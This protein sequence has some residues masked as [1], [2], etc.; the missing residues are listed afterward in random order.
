MLEILGI[1]YGGGAPGMISKEEQ[2]VCYLDHQIV[3]VSKYCLWRRC[4]DDI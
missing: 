4:W 1:V 2:I 3:G